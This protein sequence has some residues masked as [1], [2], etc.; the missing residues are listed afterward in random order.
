MPAPALL[1]N[2]PLVFQHM[3][4]NVIPLKLF[5]NLF[6]F[7]LNQLEIAEMRVRCWSRHGRSKS[8]GVYINVYACN[9]LILN[10]YV[11]HEYITS[12]PI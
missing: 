6:S 8:I 7:S 5:K 11:K 2:I 12:E 10:D 4:Y 3:L 1:L 9:E